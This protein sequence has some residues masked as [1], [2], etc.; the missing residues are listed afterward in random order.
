M[1]ANIRLGI[2]VGLIFI[3]GWALLSFLAREQDGQIDIPFLVLFSVGM[4]FVAA[5]SR[6]AYSPMKRE[7]FDFLCTTPWQPGRRLPFRRFAPDAGEIVLLLAI[8]AFTWFEGS[9]AGA[10]LLGCWGTLTCAGTAIACWGV[11]AVALFTALLGVLGLLLMASVSLQHFFIAMIVLLAFCCWIE[12]QL[13][14]RAWQDRFTNAPRHNAFID[15]GPG[16]SALA[17][18]VY[19]T[20]LSRPWRAVIGATLGLLLLGAS[21]A[22]KRMMFDFAFNARETLTDLGFFVVIFAGIARLISYRAALRPRISLWSRIARFH[23]VDPGFDLC[24][25][26]LLAGL[27]TLVLGGVLDPT[28][29][30]LFVRTIT[31]MAALAVSLA[32][33]PTSESWRLTAPGVVPLVPPKTTSK[34]PAR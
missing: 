4:A 6:V 26:P 2:R 13:L 10:I 23:P 34:P 27:G 9:F 12:R 5:H 32:I 7:H 29:D 20:T 8:G 16:V 3:A 14:A 24:L 19:P 21:V 25:L 22:L 17:P 18:A 33:G 15:V 11:G 30:G 1:N 31:V 28:S